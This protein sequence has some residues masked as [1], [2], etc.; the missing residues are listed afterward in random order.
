MPVNRPADWVEVRIGV[1]LPL[2]GTKFID[3]TG[4]ISH[5]DQNTRSETAPFFGEK[6]TA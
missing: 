1:L 4:K 6:L 3:R 5:L 2:G